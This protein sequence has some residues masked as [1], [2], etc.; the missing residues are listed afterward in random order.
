MLPIFYKT[1]TSNSTNENIHQLKRQIISN[2]WD[3]DNDYK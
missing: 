1:S 3:T 2:S